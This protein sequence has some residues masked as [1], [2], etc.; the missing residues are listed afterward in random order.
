M[1]NGFPFLSLFFARGMGEETRLSLA[2][3]LFF[4]CFPCGD[5]KERC[6]CGARRPGMSAHMFKRSILGCCGWDRFWGGGEVRLVMVKML[7]MEMSL[8]ELGY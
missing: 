3:A 5:K 2:P 6:K 7:E 1:P 8:G 4:S